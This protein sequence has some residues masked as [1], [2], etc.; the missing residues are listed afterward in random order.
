M[1]DVPEEHSRACACACARDPDAALGIVD[2]LERRRRGEDARHGNP[3]ASIQITPLLI[4]HNGLRCGS[5]QFKL[6]ITQGAIR[7]QP[8]G[9]VGP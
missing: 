2:H 5:A 4:V 1:R 6:K 9:R 3:S 7:L 8:A